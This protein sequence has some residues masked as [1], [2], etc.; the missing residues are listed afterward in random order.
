MNVR[1]VPTSVH[2][3]VDYVTASALLAAPDVLRL[4]QTSPSAIAPRVTGAMAAAYS[5][6]TDYEL[7]VK[8]LL[9]MK[10]HLAMDA[11]SGAL[12]AG[13]PWATR[14]AKRGP[15]YWVPHL[16]VGLAEIGLALTTKTEPART[17]RGKAARALNAY[18]A[19]KGVKHAPRAIRA[20]PVGRVAGV[21]TLVRA[22]R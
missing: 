20:A 1:V 22:L 3:I 4:K 11:A 21:A 19:W 7:G 5:T 16:A 15:R 13:L 2:G 17:K 9:P 6:L 18:G 8:R 12:L 14:S 10:A